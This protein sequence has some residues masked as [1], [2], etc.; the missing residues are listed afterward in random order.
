MQGCLLSNA[1]VAVGFKVQTN[2]FI[3]TIAS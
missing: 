2:D 1:L 3:K